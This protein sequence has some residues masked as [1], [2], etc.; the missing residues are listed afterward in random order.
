MNLRGRTRSL[1][2][3]DRL[4]AL[5]VLVGPASQAANDSATAERKPLASLG[6]CHPFLG[7]INMPGTLHAALKAKPTSDPAP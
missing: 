1:I 5:D 6:R 7:D 2:P 4:Q 3:G